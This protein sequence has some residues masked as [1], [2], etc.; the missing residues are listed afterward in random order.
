MT[1]LADFLVR[2]GGALLQY[3][4][5]VHR[6]E[7]VLN[8]TAQHYDHT[9]EVFAV[10]TGLWLSISPAKKETHEPV[11]RLVRVYNWS[12]DLDKLQQLDSLFN[13]VITR[14]T[15]LPKALVRLKK[16]T[17]TSTT[18]P[19]WREL[20]VTGSICG[21]AA[22]F[23]GGQR[24]EVLI[25]VILGLLIVG[26]FRF[27][28]RK[29]QTR[30]L[31]DF[32]VG[33][34]TGLVVW[35][36]TTVQPDLLRKPMILAGI[37]VIVP[38]MTLTVGLGELVHRQLVSGGAR[39]LQAAMV[40]ISMILGLSIAIKLESWSLGGKPVVLGLA[41]AGVSHPLWLTGLVACLAGLAF[42]DL[43]NV[44]NKYRVWAAFSCLVAWVVS[45]A[46]ASI[47]TSGPLAAFGGAFGLGLY[48]NTLTRLTGSP[49]QIF[50][51][52]GL[53]LLVPGTVGFL[54]F[55]RFLNGDANQ[56]VLF[57]FATI[58]NGGA[59][60]TGLIVA[61]AALSPRKLL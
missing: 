23:F 45:T 58:M 22:L 2:L 7:E 37:I 60:I 19:L 30:L 13:L 34:L 1:H 43:F 53:F 36:A 32:L 20:L 16:I 8:L 28:Q 26:L 31:I 33:L 48:A 12:V 39:L 46:A 59:L 50:L 17:H 9:C 55:E 18:Y 38:G 44:P 49:N 47:L 5:P 24:G 61:N 10:P 11:I 51:L 14:S 4:S 29:Q 42:A 35:G 21:S 40:F 15:S 54:G 41:E 25:S 27:V 3:G 56:G 52:P 6:I 57:A